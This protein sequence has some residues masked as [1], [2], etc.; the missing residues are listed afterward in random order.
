MQTSIDKLKYQ[1]STNKD[2]F[3]D[4]NVLKHFHSVCENLLLSCRLKNKFKEALETLRIAYDFISMFNLDDIEMEWL[5]TNSCKIK[6]DLWKV[7]SKEYQEMTI[8][9]LL[10]IKEE[11]V[12]KYLLQEIRV[13]NT[14]K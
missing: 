8:V 2:Y 10:D 3:K 6:R 1:F 13:Y 4:P 7:K 14:F 5:V 11:L 9:D 12:D